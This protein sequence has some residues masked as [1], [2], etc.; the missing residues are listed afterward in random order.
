MTH[1]LQS[2][3]IEEICRNQVS[4]KKHGFTRK[5]VIAMFMAEQFAMKLDAM[6]ETTE[7]NSDT[8]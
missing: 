7:E 8:H 4:F 5:K 2:P 3:Q 6:H 1:F